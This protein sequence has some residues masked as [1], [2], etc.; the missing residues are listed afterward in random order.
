MQN[1]KQAATKLGHGPNAGLPWM[2]IL[3]SGGDEIINSD[4]P[5][6]NIGCPITKNEC[7]YF[8]SMIEQSKQHL[9]RQQINL[10]ATALDAYAA[11]KR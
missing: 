4:S 2:T 1:G 3:D 9:S 8:I 11:P 5:Q 10:I 6:G 7:A